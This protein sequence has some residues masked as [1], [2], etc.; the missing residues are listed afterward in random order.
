M[1]TRF[2]SPSPDT[3]AVK[4][5]PL[6][7]KFRL[8]L[9][10]GK[11]AGVLVQLLPQHFRSLSTF[12]SPMEPNAGL[13]DGPSA[14]GALAGSTPRRPA[15][16][17][18]QQP[19][20]AGAGASS[21]SSVPAAGSL[22]SVDLDAEAPELEPVQA[23]AD[24]PGYDRASRRSQRSEP[25]SRD[26]PV[27]GRYEYPGTFRSPPLYF[28]PPNFTVRYDTPDAE[29]VEQ[30]VNNLMGYVSIMHNMVRTLPS[31]SET[32]GFKC[33]VMKSALQ[34]MLTVFREGRIRDGLRA[35]ERASPSPHEDP[36][37]DA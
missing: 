5:N 16:H 31:D 36:G 9:S 7:E 8:G 13:L 19:P 10:C 32:L 12:N 35:L 28:T 30:M 33:L 29:R 37:D 27:A 6:R 2:K 17:P 21:S 23:I 15:E 1:C 3:T 25:Y 24:G 11:G 26:A 34:G 14:V 4:T 22:L 18:P 20:D